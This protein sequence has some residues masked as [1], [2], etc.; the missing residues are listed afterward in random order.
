MTGPTLAFFLLVLASCGIL[1]VL[2]IGLFRNA[3]RL[4][5]SVKGFSDA[6][7]PIVDEIT[8]GLD[9]ASRHAGRL[10]AATSRL[11]SRG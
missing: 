5:R 2:A 7:M 11:R 1:V 4:V 8:A 3:M 9:T 6:A 10:S